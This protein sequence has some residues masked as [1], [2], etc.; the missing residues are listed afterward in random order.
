MSAPI[1][2]MLKPE[3]VIDLAAETH[4]RVAN[5]LTLLVSLVRMQ[6]QSLAKSSAPLGSAEARLLLEGIAARITTVSQLHRLLAHVP[7]GG[8]PMDFGAHLKDV[9]QTLV[10][11]VSSPQQPVCLTQTVDNCQLAT[12]QVQPLTMVLCEILINALKYSHPAGVPVRLTVNCHRDNE[13]ALIIEAGDD[14]VGLPE[15][16]DTVRGGG[17][18]FKV[19]RS[20]CGQIGAGLQIDSSELGLLFRIRLP[21]PG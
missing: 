15:D 8:G 21:S 5:S 4:H 14:G 9:C 19:I 6:A 12:S 17:L 10:E 20:L 11:I 3:A 1:L 16:F 7:D 13:G 18:G 2:L